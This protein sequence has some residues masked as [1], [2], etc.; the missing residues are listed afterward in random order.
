MT[1]EKGRIPLARETDRDAIDA[2]LKTIGAVDPEK[3][4]LVHIKNTLE[5]GKID[6]SSSLLEEIKGR[7]DL[8]LAGPLEPFSF[9]AEGNLRSAFA[10]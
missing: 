2:A 5:I 6:I 7:V 4:R 10:S 9:D 8:K 3:A 1:P